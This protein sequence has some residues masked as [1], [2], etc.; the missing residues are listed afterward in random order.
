MPFVAGQ[1]IGDYRV[2]RL[3]GKGGMGEVYQVTHKPT[4]VVRALK[5][6][7]AQRHDAQLWE[8]FHN[9]AVIQS[10]LSHPNIA[11]FYEMF[12]VDEF[13]CLVMEYVEGQTLAQRLA[14]HGPLDA[15]EAARIMGQLCDGLSYLH[16]KRV[17][18][19]DLKSS[20]VKVQQDG[21]VKLL[22]FG[23]AR[24]RDSER[25]T[26]AG[27]IVGTPQMLAPEILQGGLAGEAAEI[28]S[29]GVLAYELITGKLP[30][31]GGS[32]AELYRSIQ[33]QA[34]LPPSYVRA[35][36]PP[37]VERIVMR[38]LE[39][40]PSRRYRSSKDLSEQFQKASRASDSPQASK[41]AW[42]PGKKQLLLGAA[43]LLIVIWMLLP[44]AARDGDM[45]VTIDVLDG[46]AE[47]Y[48]A[49]RKLGTTPFQR[50]ARR[51]ETVQLELRRE[52][53]ESQPVQFEVNDR[54]VYSYTLQ[55]RKV[56]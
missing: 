26:R 33:E 56:F 20:N 7:S 21:A 24:L 50:P 35:G 30:F 18:H 37:D 45:V 43:A 29:A 46:A 15:R 3:I 4:G 22:D 32:D 49:G 11:S 52:G 44:R 41:L 38:C 23:I 51:G 17:Y 28:W 6:L 8:R 13:P 1:R 53:F 54:K 55:P 14:T 27:L 16:E 19:R 39:K 9:E 48:E 10:Q 47:V 34:P 40:N 31:S 12:L 5:T 25:L 36:I 42:R 2:D